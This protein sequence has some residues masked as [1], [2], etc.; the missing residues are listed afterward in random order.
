[1]IIEFKWNVTADEDRPSYT[2]PDAKSFFDPIITLVKAKFGIEF[3]E[4]EDLFAA[5]GYIEADFKFPS[6]DAAEKARPYFNGLVQRYSGKGLR[7]GVYIRLYSIT[8]TEPLLKYIAY[9][10]K[11]PD[12]AIIFYPSSKYGD[13]RAIIRKC[14][15]IT[16]IKTALWQCQKDMIEYGFEGNARF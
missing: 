16:P 1:M 7:S 2:D 5:P 4:D 6:L 15:E 13:L 12:S 14:R 9:V 8:T 10:F 3:N 11:Y